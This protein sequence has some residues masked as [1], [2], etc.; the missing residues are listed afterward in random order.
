VD[1][2]LLSSAEKRTAVERLRRNDYTLKRADFVRL[3]RDWTRTI[4]KDVYDSRRA[5]DEPTIG[6]IESTEYVA[7]K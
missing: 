5:G 3:N 2:N 4:A 6:G 1:R 7:W